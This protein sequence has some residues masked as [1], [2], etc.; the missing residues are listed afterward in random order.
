MKMIEV[1]IDTKGGISMETKGF[2]GE[3]CREATRELERSLGLVT[4]DQQTPE[5]FLAST[6]SQHQSLES[7]G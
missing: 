4:R 2:A 6:Q 3:A 5:M 1:L 7:A